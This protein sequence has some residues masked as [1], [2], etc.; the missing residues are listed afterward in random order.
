MNKNALSELEYEDETCRIKLKSTAA[1]TIVAA[2]PAVSAPVQAAPQPSVQA[3]RDK[4]PQQSQRKPE[5]RQRA[6]GQRP[7]PCPILREQK[8][9]SASSFLRN[10]LPRDLDTGDLLIIVLLLLMAGD[11]PE[12]QNNALLTLA[13]Y[14][15]M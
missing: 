14:L 12:E 5:P 15:F 1:Q 6:G 10:L 11:H 4:S 13:I 7:K 3:E 9:S 8:E 2:A